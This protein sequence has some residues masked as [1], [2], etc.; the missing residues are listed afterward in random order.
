MYYSRKVHAFPR[1]ELIHRKR[2]QK[3]VM[4]WIQIALSGGRYFT[5]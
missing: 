5:V 3:A 1:P 2:V 4:L